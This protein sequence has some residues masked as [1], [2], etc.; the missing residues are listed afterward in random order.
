MCKKEQIRFYN[1]SEIFKDDERLMAFAIIEFLHIDIDPLSVYKDL[2]ACKYKRWIDQLEQ[3]S[4]TIRHDI[5]NEWC[6]QKEFE[7]DMKCDLIWSIGDNRMLEFRGWKLGKDE[8][9]E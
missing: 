3:I 4:E 9:E 5:L 6:R 2:L 7:L 8:V 1:V